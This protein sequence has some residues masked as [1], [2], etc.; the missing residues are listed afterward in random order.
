VNLGGLVIG[1]AGL[2]VLCQVFGGDVLRRVR[3]LG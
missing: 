1:L 2:L 3:V